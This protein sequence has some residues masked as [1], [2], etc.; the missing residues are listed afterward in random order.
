MQHNRWAINEP[1]LKTLKT[2]YKINPNSELFKF[3]PTQDPTILLTLTEKQKKAQEKSNMSRHLML[4]LVF[5]QAETYFD[6][7]YRRSVLHSS[8]TRRAIQAHNPLTTILT[9]YGSDIE[10][11]LLLL[12]AEEEAVE[13]EGNALKDFGTLGSH[14]LSKIAERSEHHRKEE[15]PWIIPHGSG[16]D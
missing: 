6:K 7:I 5:N 9:S 2:I 16:Q 15:I 13:L 10:R 12:G 1:M 3:T 8:C 4:K 11:S 14:Y